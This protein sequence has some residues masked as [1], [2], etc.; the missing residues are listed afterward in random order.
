MER[1]KENMMEAEVQH[2]KGDEEDVNPWDFF[3]IASRQ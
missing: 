3:Y 2:L 1:N